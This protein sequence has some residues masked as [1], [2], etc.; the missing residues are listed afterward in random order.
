ME[1]TDF[2]PNVESR[3]PEAENRC[4]PIA[5]REYL[6]VECTCFFCF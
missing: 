5:F 4:P 6:Q 1:G 2:P 3:E